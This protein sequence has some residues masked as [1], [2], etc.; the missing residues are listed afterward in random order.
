MTLTVEQEA[1]LERRLRGLLPAEA[2]EIPRADRSAPLPLSWGQRGLWFLHR[3]NPQGTEYTVPMQL[4]LDGPLDVRRLRRSLDALVRRHEIL[5]TVYSAADGEPRQ[6]IRPARP[7]EL[8]DGAD[9]AAFLDRPFDLAADQPIRALLT[10]VGPQRHLLTL[11]VHHIAVDGWSLGILR[12]ELFDQYTGTSPVGS[13]L[14]YADFAAW[15]TAQP[16]GDL[17]YWTHRLDGLEPLALPADRPRRAAADHRGDSVSF[18]VPAEI[19]QTVLRLGRE[20]DA[21]P[22]MTLMAA[23]LV[24][25][26]RHTGR[27]DLAVGTPVH[28]RDRTEIEDV[29]GY[30]VNT[31]VLR[32]DL[33][34]DLTFGELLD[35]VR[36]ATL[37]DYAHVDVPFER[38]VTALGRPLVEVMVLVDE[39]VR[40]RTQH[41]DLTV[42][43]EPVPSRTAKFEL[44]AAFE[45]LPDGTVDGVLEYA[46]A[47]FDRARMNRLASHVGVLLAGI[48]ARPDAPLSE[49]EILPSAER[50]RLLIERNAT[51]APYTPACLHDLIAAQAA[52][53][54]DAIAVRSAEGETTYAE[55]ERRANQIAH[56]L[57]ARGVGVET[58]VGV[59]CERS[60]ELLP[61]LLGIL[62]T[63][64]HYVPLDPGYPAKRRDYMLTRTGARLVL[65]TSRYR[66]L[67][68]RVPAIVLDDE[69]LAALPASP[70]LVKVDSLNLAYVIF[71]SG[72]TGYPKGVM[73]SHA[74]VTH[75]LAWCREAYNADE[76]D[77]APVHSSL[78]FDLTVTG[79]FLPL[80]CGRTVTLVPEDEHPV[81]GLAEAL[82][83]GR[84]YSFVKLTPAHLEIL[85][86]CLP[87]EAADAAAHLVVGGEQLTAEALAFW[88]DRA[89]GVLVANE[90]GHTETSVANVIK[91]IRAGDAVH[92]PVSIGG[93]I[94]NTV[95]YLLDD[96]MRPVPEGVPGEVYAGGTGVARGFAGAPGL[97]ADRYVPNPFEPGRLYRSGDLARYRADGSLEFI[98][99]TDQQV[100][101]R[102]YRIEPGEVETCAAAHPAVREAVVV[103][104]DG[105]LACYVTPGDINVAALRAHLLD[106]LPRY[107]VPDSLTALNLLPL[108]ANG[109]VDRDALPDPDLAGAAAAASAA[110]ATVVVRARDRI[111]LAVTRVWEEVL[112][113][114]PIGVTDDFFASGGHSMSAVTVV[115]RLNAELDADLGLSEIF[116]HR[117]IRRLGERIGGTAGA[118]G[119][120][121]LMRAGVGGPTLFLAPPTAGSPFPYLPLVDLLPPDW[122]V[123]GL[124]DCGDPPPESVEE[125]ASRFLRG[126]RRVQ[127]DGPLHLAG[128]SFGGTVAYEMAV[129][130]ERAGERVGS[131][132]VIDSSVLGTD[133]ITAQPEAESGDA[134]ALFGR[135]L[136]DLPPD[137]LIAFTQDEAMAELLSQARAR[138]LVP[139]G[140]GGETIKRMAAVYLANSRATNRYRATAVLNTDIHLVR[141][142]R[143]H[144]ELGGP[145]VGPESWRA[146]TRGRVHET[147]VDADHWSIVEPPHVATL[148]EALIAVLSRH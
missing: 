97:T 91:L 62:K 144:P 48:A 104:R 8:L 70:P 18:T 12:Q 76:G 89:P 3:L 107:L 23:F 74:G 46:T 113:R 55:L 137:E 121:V 52:R 88:R 64:G 119:A 56:L 29:V 27:N 32:G 80:L 123:H 93:P 71:T 103:V 10:R 94:W 17:A 9:V 39:S 61:I 128:W 109:K 22:F 122:S 72:S 16:T 44:T 59:L 110:A 67:K 132:T 114:S 25:L 96:Q 81:A 95:V 31:A 41:G 148:A 7:F 78:A 115:D 19:G 129:R 65:T 57:L 124:E 50:H 101:V 143:R 145:Q 116:R 125:L 1:E 26:G 49:L 136:L 126:A 146:L 68:G 15:Q 87:S 4:V 47:L 35:R 69:N 112:G 5:R 34:G 92:S 2:T 139:A 53:K 140:A 45:V 13:P 77:G 58:P 40:T 86:R 24:V 43:E 37:E 51:A 108:T 98:G 118:G 82:S 106:R 99:R 36:R 38:L 42:A 79:L 130:L 100:K 30:F 142:T 147:R 131:L 105:A 134:L 117:T 102:G 111:E 28:G 21:T 14:Q 11:A 135:G 90:Y 141:S 85:Q 120:T 6:E 84:R 54:P 60:T 127:P 63:G 33:S 83:A 138:E 20:R 75:Y 66:A 73:I 133:A